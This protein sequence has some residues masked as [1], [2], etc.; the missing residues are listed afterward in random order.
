MDGTSLKLERVRR[1][2]RQYRVAAALGVPQTTL[3]AIENGRRPV[4]V[5]EAERIAE[6]IRRLA[7]EGQLARRAGDGRAG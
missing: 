2:L 6:A 7:A 5:A 1:G 4:T 3:C